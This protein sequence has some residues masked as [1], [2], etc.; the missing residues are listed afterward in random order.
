MMCFEMLNWWT[1]QKCPQQA[2]SKSMPLKSNG[3]SVDDLM[4]WVKRQRRY[5]E[6]LL[7]QLRSTRILSFTI[8]INLFYS[9]EIYPRA[10]DQGYNCTIDPD[11][12]DVYNE[13]FSFSSC[14]YSLRIVRIKF[15][16]KVYIFTSNF[17]NHEIFS[18]S[19]DIFCPIGN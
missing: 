7:L 1:T 8:W 19:S 10:L 5:H 6:L 4:I 13:W 14:Q 17:S 11:K 3:E 16:R 12:K 2:G 9:C 18:I 15:D